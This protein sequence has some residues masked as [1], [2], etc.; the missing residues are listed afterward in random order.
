M[1]PRTPSRDL[2]GKTLMKEVDASCDIDRAEQS[3]LLA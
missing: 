2:K 1:S 3:V